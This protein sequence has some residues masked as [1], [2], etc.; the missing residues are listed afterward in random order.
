[1]I[2]PAAKRART[3]SIWIPYRLHLLPT[4]ERH[5]WDG[6]GELGR[7]WEYKSITQSPEPR[8]EPCSPS[9]GRASF[10]LLGWLPGKEPDRAQV[11]RVTLMTL[12]GHQDAAAWLGCPMGT[13]TVGTRGHLCPPSSGRDVC[14]VPREE[15]RSSGAVLFSQCL[16]FLTGNVKFPKEINCHQ[17]PGPSA[18]IPRDPGMSLQS[19]P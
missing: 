9:P 17:A 3:L 5:M 4:V 6:Q 7:V 11:P 19:F 1:M 18:S 2:Y 10:S 15:G 8:R 14:S 16:N 13:G 12:R